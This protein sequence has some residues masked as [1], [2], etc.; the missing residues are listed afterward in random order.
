MNAHA[1]ASADWDARVEKILAGVRRQAR[2]LL[3][4]GMAVYGGGSVVI[5]LTVPDRGLALVLQMFLFQLCVMYF[6][7][8][9][10]YVCLRG[11]ML[12]GLENARETVPVFSRLAD[13]A[14]RITRAADD[15][16]AGRGPVARAIAD[17]KGEISGL[18]ADIRGRTA[19]PAPPLAFDPFLEP[20]VLKAPPAKP[21]TA[22]DCTYVQNPEG[23]LTR[24]L[25][26]GH[27]DSE[28]PYTTPVTVNGRVI[29]GT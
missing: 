15:Y 23:G 25:L 19:L 27:P 3:S 1:A 12:V 10:M 11:S 4:V 17:L 28:I 7:V 14:D 2:Q 21:S 29:E 6:G 24:I 18:R 16:E 26:N 5:L 13:A 22:P 9:R 8:D 20:V